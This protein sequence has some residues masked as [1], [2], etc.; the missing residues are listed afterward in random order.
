MSHTYNIVNGT[1][2][3]GR[4]GVPNPAGKDPRDIGL[5]NLERQAVGLNND[6]INFDFDNDPS[7]PATTANPH[8]L[9]E[10]GLRD[11][12]G[13]DRRPSYSVAP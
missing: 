7:T 10:N 13:R 1:L 12:L 5:N 2:Q 4:Y 9:T 3:N 11:E 6:G 8:P